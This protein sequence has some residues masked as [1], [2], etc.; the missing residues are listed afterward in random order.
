MVLDEFGG[1]VPLG[2][3][4]PERTDEFLLLRNAEWPT[5]AEDYAD[6]LQR[7]KQLPCEFFTEGHTAGFGFMD[8]MNRLLAGEQPNPFHAPQECREDLEELERGFQAQLARERAQA[9]R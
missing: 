4:V 7:A 2:A 6:M 1:V 8:K 3:G 9:S 5:I